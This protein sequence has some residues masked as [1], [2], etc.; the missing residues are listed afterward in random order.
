MRLR[1]AA[2][3]AVAAAGIS[4]A[5]CGEPDTTILRPAEQGTIEGVWQISGN[6]AI[7]DIKPEP[8]YSGRYKLTII[9]SPDYSVVPG[10]FF[11]TLAATAT[12]GQY[13]AAVSI[14][15]EGKT[16]SSRSTRNFIFEFDESHSRCTLRPYSAGKRISLR[17]LLP[18]LFRITIEDRGSRPEGTVGAVRID[19]PQTPIAL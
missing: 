10:S 8:G 18:Y 15:P 1:A 19:T 11:G 12:P 17:R 4:A 7:F 6:G 14:D 13:D 3:I 9:D 5:T 16:G 2:F